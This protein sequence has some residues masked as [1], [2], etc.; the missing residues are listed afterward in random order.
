L[1]TS[2]G[3]AEH[4]RAPSSA[5]TMLLQ[6]EFGFVPEG[7]SVLWRASGHQQTGSCELTRRVAGSCRA[8]KGGGA[9]RDARARPQDG[10]A[11]RHAR[12][13]D[14]PDR[15]APP[16]WARWSLPPPSS[17]ASSFAPGV[18]PAN[19]PFRSSPASRERRAWPPRP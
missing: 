11:R 19:G 13:H 9:P 14:G 2:D 4:Q 6:V 7:I 5:S 8:R 18:H 10:P 17:L 1:T 12:H 3:A 15:L 16:F